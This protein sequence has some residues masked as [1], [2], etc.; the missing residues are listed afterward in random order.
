MRG[1]LIGLLISPLFFIWLGELRAGQNSDE[2]CADFLFGEPP[3]GSGMKGRSSKVSKHTRMSRG[4]VRST[5][6]A[7][8]NRQKKRADRFKHPKRDRE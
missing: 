8:S 7:T 1:I 5:Y 4:R 2:G 3:G 6:N